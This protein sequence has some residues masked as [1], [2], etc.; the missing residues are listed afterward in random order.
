LSPPIQSF[1]WAGTQFVA[2]L[3]LCRIGEGRAAGA[4]I[5]E[6]RAPFR[7]R[8]REQMEVEFEARA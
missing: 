7:A 8:A 6:R 4:E 1:Q 2:A 3:S 5:D